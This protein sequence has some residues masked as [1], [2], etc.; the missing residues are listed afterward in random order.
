MYLLYFSHWVNVRLINKHRC[1]RRLYQTHRVHSQTKYRNRLSLFLFCSLACF[2]PSMRVHAH[3]CGNR[4]VR[5]MYV[6]ILYFSVYFVFSSVGRLSFVVT[7]VCCRR[8]FA[9]IGFFFWC[10][11]GFSRS[12]IFGSCSSSDEYAFFWGRSWLL[13]NERVHSIHAFIRFSRC[14]NYVC[15]SPLCALY[16]LTTEWNRKEK[17]KTDI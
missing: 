17:T 9:A 3:E 8:L 11:L 2:C 13:Y 7:V 15:V 1:R 16:G 5:P 6:Y 10:S 12:S 14:F 4:S